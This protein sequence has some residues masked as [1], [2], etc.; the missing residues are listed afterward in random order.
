MI[1]RPPRSTLF[2]YTTLFRSRGIRCVARQQVRELRD[3]LG[4][5]EAHA[6][7]LVGVSVARLRVLL[8]DLEWRPAPRIPAS[9]VS[10]A[11]RRQASRAGLTFTQAARTLGVSV[12]W[13]QRE[14]RLGTVRV[15][16]SEERRV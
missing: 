7:R 8:R 16:R 12:A 3:E 13:I 4:Y 15:L 6:A 10:A 2:P 1:R 14:I 11:K 5:R 9:V